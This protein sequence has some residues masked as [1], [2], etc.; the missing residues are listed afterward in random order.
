MP[1][2]PSTPRNQPIRRPNSP[3]FRPFNLTGIAA[4]TPTG[5][6][7]LRNLYSS[8]TPN[9]RRP[10]E[11]NVYKTPTPKRSPPKNNKTAKKPRRGP[12]SPT[13]NPKRTLVL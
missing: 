4:S 10:G 11:P 5:P 13:F 1:N 8:P 3:R 12:N 6:L 7:N 9:R 2:T